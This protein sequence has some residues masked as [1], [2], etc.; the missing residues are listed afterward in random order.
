MEAQQLLVKIDIENEQLY[1]RI[2][3]SPYGGSNAYMNELDHRRWRHPEYSTYLELKRNQT[4]TET[5]KNKKDD[6]I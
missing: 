4:K 5:T 6:S 1:G 3:I 2:Q